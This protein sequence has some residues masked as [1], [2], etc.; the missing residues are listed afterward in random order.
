MLLV[1][2]GTSCPVPKVIAPNANRETTRPVLP[3]VVYCIKP[4]LLQ[5]SLLLRYWL[6][7]AKISYA[8]YIFRKIK[9]TSQDVV[10]TTLAGDKNYK[11]FAVIESGLDLL[12][13]SLVVDLAALVRDKV[14]SLVGSPQ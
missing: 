5:W 12:R 7:S 13:R 9:I 10:F 3:R 4:N 8:E 2:P 11:N 1:T 6:S 14:A